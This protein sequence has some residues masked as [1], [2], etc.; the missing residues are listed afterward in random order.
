[1]TFDFLKEKEL[2]VNKYKAPKSEKI[3]KEKKERK[4]MLPP[5]KMP[6]FN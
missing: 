1:M 3:V 4:F 6:E 2:K 5:F